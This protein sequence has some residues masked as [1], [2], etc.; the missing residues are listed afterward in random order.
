MYDRIT[1]LVWKLVWA[2]F[3]CMLIACG[4]V[5]SDEAYQQG[6]KA[7]EEGLTA[8]N[9]PHDQGSYRASKWLD[10]WLEGDEK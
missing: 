1:K 5:T 9:N 3:I 4:G 2:L 6:K 8:E 7:R 10:G